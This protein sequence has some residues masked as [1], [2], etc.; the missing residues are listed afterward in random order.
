MEPPVGA[1][2]GSP[3]RDA[4]DVA[5]VLALLLVVLGHLL[6]AVIDR[7]DGRLRGANLLAL[8]PGWAALA[9][10]APM[11]VFFAAAGWANATSPLAASTARLRALVGLGAVVVC[12]WSAAV[13]VTELV[14]GRPGVVGDGA[15]IA[16]QPL[17]FV[18]AYV[19]LVAAAR[20]LAVLAARHA[21][22]VV[23]GALLVLGVLDAARFGLGAPGWIGWPGFYLAWGTP[24]V[25]G[26]WWRARHEAGAFHERRV[27][28][29]LALASGAGCLVLVVLAG[30][31]PAL[32][33]AVPGARSNT[34]PPTLFTAVA[35]LTQVGLLLVCARV[36]DRAG[37]RWRGLWDRA[38][39]AAVGV[40]VWHLTAL[41]LCAAVI[42]AGLPVP[43]RLTTWWWLTRPLWWLAVLTLTAGLVLLTRAVRPGRVRAGSPRRRAVAG[44]VLA[45]AAGGVIGLRG[46]RTVA[47]AITCSALF[48]A[49]WYLLR[50][51]PDGA[52]RPPLDPGTPAVEAGGRYRT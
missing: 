41:A 38:G 51:E 49:A 30:Y 23:A 48:L 47:L 14:A 52:S 24:W 27:G 5:R 45:A 20:P 2:R 37:S 36:L 26:A 16:T 1:V 22:P 42:A 43:E 21:A 8:H 18:A 17:W 31:D 28:L 39:E 15:R 6:L 11:P 50:E 29:A 25:V 33:D 13:V 3:H 7:H 19:P 10:L 35:A 4:I 46:P 40:Y 32:I 44:V 34:T 12:S 9:V